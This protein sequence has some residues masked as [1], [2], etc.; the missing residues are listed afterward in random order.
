MSKQTLLLQAKRIS[1]HYN[2]H[3]IL[4]DV[5]CTVEPGSLTAVIGPNGAGKS[6]LLRILGHLISPTK[7]SVSIESIGEIAS[8]SAEKRAKYIGWVADHGPLPFAF[9][10][11]DTV[12]LGRYAWHKGIPKVVDDEAT[13]SALRQMEIEHLAKR[14]IRSLSSGERQKT[15][16]ARLIAGETPI[17]LLDEPLASLDIGSSLKLLSLLRKK[18]QDGATICLTIHDLPLAYRFADHILCL[19]NG[20]LVADGPSK[21]VLLSPL[22]SQAFRVEPTI[23]PGLMLSTVP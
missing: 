17:L 12:R 6:T 9:S 16:I 10:V 5:S 23:E 21:D 20:T 18:A 22:V 7:G 11:F 19:A 4:R 1:F 8:M 2:H 3:P 14:D 13:L 15:M